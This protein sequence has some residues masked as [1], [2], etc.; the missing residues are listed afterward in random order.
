MCTVASSA[1]G[2]ETV[3][4]VLTAVELLVDSGCGVPVEPLDRLGQRVLGQ[5]GRRGQLADGHGAHPGA[6]REVGRRV[7]LGHRDG[8][9]PAVLA[10][11]K[12]YQDG[13]RSGAL[14]ISRP[15]RS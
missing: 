6:R 11:S 8:R 5:S 13:I 1:A 15:N 9:E 12:T 2:E 3:V 7:A 4:L 14:A 10:E